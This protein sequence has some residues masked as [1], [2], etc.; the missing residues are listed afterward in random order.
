MPVVSPEKL[1]ALQRSAQDVRNVR[2]LLDFAS[3]IKFG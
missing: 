3:N 2:L 1:A